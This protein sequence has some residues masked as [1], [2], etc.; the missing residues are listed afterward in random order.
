[1]S[2]SITVSI[3]SHQQG[4]MLEPLLVDL[5]NCESIAK[6]LI[7]LNVPETAPEVPAALASRVEIIVNSVP[8]GFGTNHNAAFRETE[9]ELFCILNPD[10]SLIGDPF[11][12]LVGALGEGAGLVA[13]AVVAP[14]GSIEDSIRRFPNL[15]QLTAK[16]LGRFDGRYNFSLGDDCF[17]PDWVAGMFMLVESEAFRRVGGF[18]E[19]YFLYY[20][21]VDLCARFWAAGIPVRAC[22]KC[23]I[24]HRAQRES[25]RKLRYMKW[26]IASLARYLLVHSSRI[27]RTRGN[28]SGLGR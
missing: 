18:D 14:D 15:W 24:V 28:G 2:A 13:P 23:R 4:A 21:D 9:T 27:S 26:H 8:R 16:A 7:T 25:R 20:E 6:V 22:P 12:Q 17:E 5:S 11:P 1:M 10:V 3:V 19:R